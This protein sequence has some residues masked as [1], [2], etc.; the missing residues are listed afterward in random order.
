MARAVAAPLAGGDFPTEG[1]RPEWHFLKGSRGTA[2]KVL[3]FGKPITP[4]RVY[5]CPS[6][7]KILSVSP[8]PLW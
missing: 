6:A 5:P 4:I 8:W 1:V 2:T 7:V 3:M